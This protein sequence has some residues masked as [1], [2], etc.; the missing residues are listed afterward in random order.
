MGTPPA[1]PPIAEV[2]EHYFPQWQPPPPRSGWVTCLCP[3]HAEDRPSA[4]V[5]YQENRVHCFACDVSLDSIDVIQRKEGLGFVEAQRFAQSRF[6]E[7]GEDLPK[8][9]SGKSRRRVSVP[10]RFGRGGGAVQ[11]RFRFGSAS[12]T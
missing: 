3:V 8:Q 4:S 2:L 10:P 1:K 5:N 9:L 11:N 6:G 7:G 12:R